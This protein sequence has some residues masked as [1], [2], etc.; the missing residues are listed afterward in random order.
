MNL[1]TLLGTAPERCTNTRLGSVLS[2][3]LPNRPSLASLPGLRHVG[4]ESTTQRH[5]TARDPTVVASI[6][7]HTSAERLRPVPDVRPSA[8]CPT[9]ER[10]GT[11]DR[12]RPTRTSAG[13]RTHRRFQQSGR[14]GTPARTG[15]SDPPRASTDRATERRTPPILA[16]TSSRHRDHERRCHG[17]VLRRCH[18]GSMASPPPGPRSGRGP[19]RASP[20][21]FP[22]GP[23]RPRTPPVRRSRSPG[24]APTRS[25]GRGR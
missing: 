5:D 19:G 8:W 3:R 22:G 2:A 20:L 21:P 12:S 25:P 1:H 23:G 17:L 7:R 18:R 16:S 6:S 11:L 15:R 24:G 13:S 10:G 14:V 9:T 4:P